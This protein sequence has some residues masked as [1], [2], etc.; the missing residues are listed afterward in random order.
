M[1]VSLVVR[2]DGDS[3]PVNPELFGR[4]FPD[5]WERWGG[6]CADNDAAD[7]RH[8][9]AG[10]TRV[11]ISC[12]QV[13]RALKDLFAQLD[14]NYRRY[15]DDRLVDVEQMMAR[16]LRED[17]L[18]VDYRGLCDIWHRFLVLCLFANHTHSHHLARALGN[19]ISHNVQ[20]IA[21]HEDTL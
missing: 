17:R 1:V 13:N 12:R 6:L 8:C 21:N 9:L 15:G 4:W 20:R 11:H 18:A 16:C 10:H 19:I 2:I 3:I 14:T 5:F 7:M